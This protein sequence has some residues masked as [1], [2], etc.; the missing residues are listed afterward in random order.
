MSNKAILWGVF[1]VACLS[2]CATIEDVS[3]RELEVWQPD[4]IFT[5]YPKRNQTDVFVDQ[6]IHIGSRPPFAFDYANVRNAFS[7]TPAV[8]YEMYL[9]WLWGQEN[10]EITVELDDLQPNTAYIISF[11]P[12]LTLGDIDIGKTWEWRF[13]T[14]SSREFDEPNAMARPEISIDDHYPDSLSYQVSWSAVHGAVGYELQES[15]SE[16]FVGAAM[17][18]YVTSEPTIAILKSE[19]NQFYYRVRAFDGERYSRW[20]RIALVNPVERVLSNRTPEHID[21]HYPN[22]N[23]RDV[24]IDQDIHI[25]L[26]PQNVFD[27]AS[28][29]KSFTIE[30][31]VDYTMYLRWAM[32][33][34]D[35]ILTVELDDLAPNTIYYVAFSGDLMINGEQIE[36]PWEWRFTTGASRDFEE[37]NAMI[38]PE[39]TTVDH[40][41][42]SLEYEIGWRAI[43][44][45]VQYE[46]QESVDGLFK[47][48]FI[49]RTLTTNETVLT[50]SQSESNQYYYRVRAF[51]SERYSRWSRIFYIEPPN[52]SERKGDSGD[53][54][55]DAVK[56]Q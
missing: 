55:K 41:P 7:I 48:D 32:V 8:G 6:D 51:D 29:E 5:R 34:A 49:I 17:E 30:P 23:Q 53:K 42:E 15:K 24:F 52:P 40:F 9:R 3:E 37:P 43:S 10:T 28:A 31:P 16:H 2:S 13:T 11:S 56:T 47:S 26:H 27:F 1:C 46:L 50:L 39:I 38:R 20:S 22:R 18:T 4:S 54:R 33:Q 25:A 44:G 19:S 14:G 36:Q 21:A 12:D 35:T 45:A